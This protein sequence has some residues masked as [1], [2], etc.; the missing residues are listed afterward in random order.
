M[1]RVAECYNILQVEFEKKSIL[2]AKAL[3]LIGSCHKSG[4]QHCNSKT[5]TATARAKTWQ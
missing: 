4:R 3:L 1:E 5:K 2:Q